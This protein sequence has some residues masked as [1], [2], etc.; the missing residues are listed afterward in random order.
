MNILAVGKF[1]LEQAL[2]V[3]NRASNCG[4]PEKVSI[5]YIQFDGDPDAPAGAV[6]QS[7]Q[8]SIGENEREWAQKYGHV[9]N[10]VRA[11]L[12]ESAF[13]KFD[14][15]L[16]YSLLE[17]TSEAEL[18]DN[19]K[20]F[21]ARF[22]VSPDGK[23][24]SFDESGLP[25]E[26][27][28]YLK[29]HND[30]GKKK[31]HEGLLGILGVRPS[32]YW[33][34]RARELDLFGGLPSIDFAIGDE[35]DR[36][37]MDVFTRILLDPD[38]PHHPGLLIYTPNVS[39]G[40]SES[41]SAKLSI[42]MAGKSLTEKLVGKPHLRLNHSDPIQ[43]A[44]VLEALLWLDSDKLPNSISI[45]RIAMDFPFYIRQPRSTVIDEGADLLTDPVKKELTLAT[46]PF[47]G[48]SS[49]TSIPRYE[50]VIAKKLR[51]R[52]VKYDWKLVVGKEQ[53]PMDGGSAAPYENL[54]AVIGLTD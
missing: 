32:E 20:K 7:A 49:A 17:P 54:L 10:I 39:S 22:N 24:E 6:K 50:L 40:S 36:N 44:D 53:L 31:A 2:E 25:H 27:I 16:L 51:N 23:L 11:K 12:G 19:V 8:L 14:M 33:L 43:I 15:A 37:A 47:L 42:S 5:A 48:K 52:L 28:E 38:C 41:T 46:V 18:E 29:N 13:K 9:K 26:A 1:G 35:G 3:R 30:I 4:D 45:N 34:H 21:V